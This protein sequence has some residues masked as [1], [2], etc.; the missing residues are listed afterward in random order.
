MAEPILALKLAGRER[1]NFRIREKFMNATFGFPMPPAVGSLDSYI[2]SVNRF[3]ILS[4]QEEFALATRFK[5][6]NDLDAARELVLSHL[7]V[8][9]SV[10]RG[11]AGSFC[12]KP[13]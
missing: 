6:E 4:Q 7:R 3:P 13:T 1:S 8:V 12:R 9:V 11:F 10:A 2:Q 5:T